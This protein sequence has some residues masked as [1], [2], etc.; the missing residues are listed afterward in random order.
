M[1]L[2]SFYFI[3]YYYYAILYFFKLISEAQNKDLLQ[4]DYCIRNPSNERK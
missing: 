1:F 4:T 2:T 3:V